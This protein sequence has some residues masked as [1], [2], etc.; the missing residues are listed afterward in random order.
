MNLNA[1]Q[2]TTVFSIVMETMGGQKVPKEHLDNLTAELA[3]EIKKGGWEITGSIERL[4]SEAQ[5]LPW[6][7][8]ANIDA[9]LAAKRVCKN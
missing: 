9:V 3:R 2:F 7:K 6:E 4:I 5:M 1:E 8:L